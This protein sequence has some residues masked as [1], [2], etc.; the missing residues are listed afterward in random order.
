MRIDFVITELFVGGAELCL[1]ELAIGLAASGDD[2]RVFSL[3]SLPGGQQRHLVQRLEAANIPVE[4]AGADRATQF[5]SASRAVK[6][7]LASSPPDICQTFLHHANLLGTFAAKSAGVE[8]IVGGLRVAEAK[9]FRCWLE[10]QAVKRMTSLVCVSQAVAD[11]AANRLSC[12]AKKLIVIPNGVDVSRFAAAEPFCWNDIDWPADS[13]VTLFVGRLHPQK[14]LD[15]IQAQIDRLAPGGSNHRVL[16]VGDGPLREDLQR[17]AAA[18]G[19][20]RVKLLGWQP[21]IAPLIRAARVLLLPSRYEG[22]PNVVLEAMASGKPVV[23]S[24]V[25]GIQELLAHDRDQQSFVSGDTGAMA[26]LVESFLGDKTHS[27]ETGIKNQQR[28]RDKFSIA[29]MVNTY[30]QHYQMLREPSS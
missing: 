15:L 1:T 3:A 22:M 25:E 13:I 27:S 18:V 24:R 5:L 4:S 17:W 9:M 14:G 28:V 19:Q 6:S 10:R 29:T 16:L 21:E 30:R 12:P 7:W 23:C 11:F 8:T 20:D 2:V 26:A